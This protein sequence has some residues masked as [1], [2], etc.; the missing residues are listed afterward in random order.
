MSPRLKLQIKTYTK[1][2]HNSV[3]GTIFVSRDFP[4]EDVWCLFMKDFLK[5]DHLAND[6]ISYRS[7]LK[8]GISKL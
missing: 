7:Y 4:G 6:A 5:G 3:F 1:A 8:N 2:R